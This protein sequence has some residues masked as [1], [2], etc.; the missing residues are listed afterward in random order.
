MERLEE[1]LSSYSYNQSNH[2]SDYRDYKGYKESLNQS[3]TEGQPPFGFFVNP[4]EENNVLLLIILYY[5]QYL[6][7]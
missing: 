3:K 5:I 7:W 1:A 2:I 6:T 4:D